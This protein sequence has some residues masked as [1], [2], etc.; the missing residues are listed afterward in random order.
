MEL[1]GLTPRDLEPHSAQSGRVSEA[2]IRKRALSLRMAEQLHRC[3]PVVA[4]PPEAAAVSA[5]TPNGRS[6]CS[7]AS[8]GRPWTGFGL[9]PTRSPLRSLNNLPNASHNLSGGEHGR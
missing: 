7:F 6:R 3:H 1:A 8:H 5:I 9:M 2:L 4:T